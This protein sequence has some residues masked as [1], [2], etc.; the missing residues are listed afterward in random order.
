MAD[1][2]AGAAKTLSM[3]RSYKG[4]VP[5]LDEISEKYGEG[6]FESAF[7]SKVG[8]DEYRD[9][10]KTVIRATPGAAHTPAVRD[11]LDTLSV[12][13]DKAGGNLVPEDLYDIIIGK[14]PAPTRVSGAVTQLTTSRDVLTIP[15]WKYDADDIWTT[16]IRPVWVQEG[17]EEMDSAASRTT[18]ADV[19]KESIYMFTAMMSLLVTLEMVE[20]S[21]FPIMEYMAQQFNEAINLSKDQVILTGDGR[22][23]P[24][25][26][27]TAQKANESLMSYTSSG[28]AGALAADSIKKVMFSLPEQYEDSASW[29]MNKKSGAYNVD[30]LKDQNDRYLWNTGITT[31]GLATGGYK[32]RPLLGYPVIYSAFMPDVPASG[33]SDFPILFGDLKSYFFVNRIGFSIQVLREKYA[34]QGL[35]CLLGRFR[36]GGKLTMPWMMKPYLVPEA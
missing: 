6:D 17:S 14:K 15:R 16:P 26:I 13:I 32:N 31:D 25:G 2:N 23:Q 29:V 5:L 4:E 8:T 36:C 3:R 27:L 28:V 19:G 12:G 11:A 30:T 18:R 9:A 35:I 33:T 1:P 34:E 7:R 20:D 10:F 21:G 22:K 24:T